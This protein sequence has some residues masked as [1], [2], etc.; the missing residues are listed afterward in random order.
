MAWAG[1]IIPARAGFTTAWTPT[2]PPPTDHPRSRGVYCAPTSAP[3][4]PTWIIPA[5]AGFTQAAL[6]PAGQG[7][8]IIP[9][10]AGFTVRVRGPG[11]R[12]RD[13]P[14]SRGVYTRAI[15]WPAVTLGSSPLARGLHQPAPRR[16][17]RGGIIPARAGFTHQHLVGA[18]HLRDHPRSRG[19]YHPA[20]SHP[21]PSAGSSPLARGLLDD[22][23]RPDVVARII[24]ARAGFT[25]PLP[26]RWGLCRDHPRSR[27][28]YRGRYPRRGGARGSSPLARGLQT[29]YGLS[30]IQSRIIPAR[31]GFTRC[32]PRGGRRP[33]D[34]P[35]SRGV[36]M[37]ADA[38]E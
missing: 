1:G 34:H 13:H 22:P 28:V 35:R 36:Y 7:R 32:P 37:S 26:R 2:P 11:R 6:P 8:W 20:P 5:R 31:A 18:A 17:R 27:G 25:E 24:P 10:R 4:G 14:R 21:D 16:G 9:A 19:V 29:V 30:D 38:W 15:C 12:R 3:N 23:A 33:T